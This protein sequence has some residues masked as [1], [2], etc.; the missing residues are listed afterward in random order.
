MRAVIVD[1]EPAARAFLKNLLNSHPDIEVVS[2]AGDGLE[3]IEVI[4]R[5]QPDLVF[6]DIQMP[7]IDGFEILPYIKAEPL[8]IFVTAHDQ[9]AI[10]AF[11]A[12]ACD[13]LLKPVEPDRLATSIER[14]R[15]ES[16]NLEWR[17]AI[18]DRPK[19][20]QKIICRTHKTAHVVWLQHIAWIAKEGRYSNICCLDGNHYLSD[21]TID[22]LSAEIKNNS[23]FRVNRS[24]LVRRTQI[25]QFCSKNHATGEIVCS[26]GTPFTVSR[27]RLQAFKTWFFAES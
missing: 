27:S 10:K 22:Y 13:Y 11:E 17:H 7:V 16:V 26:G 4:N 18:L 23:F 12:N 2:D 3:A 19:G 21:L 9:Y 6:L 1:D 5:T 8:I 15:T 24:A 25:E 14:A 20:L